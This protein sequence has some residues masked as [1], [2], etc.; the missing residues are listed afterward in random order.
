MNYDDTEIPLDLITD[1][2]IDDILEDDLFSHL[3]GKE[4]K[5]KRNDFIKI[6]CSE[7]CKWILDSETIRSKVRNKIRK[8]RKEQ[9]LSV[10]Q[11]MESSVT[12]EK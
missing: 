3:F 6:L 5:R 10:I 4:N 9:G 11:R 12:P 8:M 1:D 7:Q 2:I